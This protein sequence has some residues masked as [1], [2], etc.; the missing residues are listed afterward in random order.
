MEF[1]LTARHRIAYPTLLPLDVSTLPINPFDKY[2]RENAF[3]SPAELAAGQVS[4]SPLSTTALAETSTQ[5]A[6]PIRLVGEDTYRANDTRLE[7]INM[8][9]W[10]TVPVTDKSAAM[11]VSRFLNA[12]NAIIGFFDP[13]TFLEDLFTG[14]TRFCSSFL[15]NSVLYVATVKPRSIRIT[16]LQ[17]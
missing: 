14:T 10:S 11:L 8:V 9:H 4:A 1:E 12:D 2:R 15:V 16:L 6:S 3:P 17:I 5:P 13:E 7:A